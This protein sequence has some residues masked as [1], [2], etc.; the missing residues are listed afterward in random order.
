MAPSAA[1]VTKRKVT[2][3]GAQLGN[4]IGSWRERSGSTKPSHSSTTRR[5]R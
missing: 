3:Q 4:A 1:A 5:S 2:T